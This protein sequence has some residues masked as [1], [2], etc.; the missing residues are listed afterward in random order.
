[1]ITGSVGFSID[2]LRRI[3]QPTI[4]VQSFVALTRQHSRTK[5]VGIFHGVKYKREPYGPLYFVVIH[6][7]L[8]SLLPTAWYISTVYLVNAALTKPMLLLYR[9]QRHILTL[10][11][12]ARNNVRLLVHP[13]KYAQRL[14]FC[15]DLVTVDYINTRPWYFIANT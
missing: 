8:G 10:L 3:S 13:K 1:M 12:S 7:L 14:V 9:L 4:Y 6:L 2:E 5:N 15:R 11:Y